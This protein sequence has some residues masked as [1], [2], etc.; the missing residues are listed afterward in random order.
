MPVVRRATWKVR[1]EKTQEF[2][3][4]VSTA[5]KILARRRVAE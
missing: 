1:P 2:L 4:N 3:A 5:K